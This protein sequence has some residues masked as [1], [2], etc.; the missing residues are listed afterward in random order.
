MAQPDQRLAPQATLARRSRTRD[1]AVSTAIAASRQY[2]SAP[3]AL[4]ITK[5]TR[6]IPTTNMVR[7]IK[8]YSGAEIYSLAWNGSAMDTR[9]SIKDIEGYLADIQLGDVSNKGREEIA[10]ITEPT[11]KYVKSSKSLPLG[12]AAS[13]GNMVADTA[14]LLIYK[15]PQR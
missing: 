4:P 9:W 10:I 13:L 1:R 7:R 6:N 8:L 15:V 14:S 12:S 2:A 5:L 11:F 3:T